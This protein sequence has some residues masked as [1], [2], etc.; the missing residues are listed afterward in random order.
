MLDKSY[1]CSGGH[2][3]TEG[4]GGGGWGCG[5]GGRYFWRTLWRSPINEGAIAVH[6]PSDATIDV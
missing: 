2:R 3:S 4:R 5:V 1:H 6:L